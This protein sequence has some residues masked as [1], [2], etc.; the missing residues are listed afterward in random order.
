M[1]EALQHVCNYC[2]TIGRVLGQRRTREDYQKLAT[3]H[4]ALFP[5]TDAM[6]FRPN[7]AAVSEEE[8]PVTS[9]NLGMYETVLNYPKPPQQPANGKAPI[10][11]ALDFLADKQP[12]ITPEWSA[13]KAVERTPKL[14]GTW[15]ISGYQKGR[16]KVYGQMVIEAGS[17]ADD[18][19]T[20]LTL[21]YAA[22]RLEF[23]RTGKGIVY[24]GYSWRGRTKSDSGASTDPSVSPAEM[25]EALFIARDGSSIDGRLYW[26]GY[27]EFGIDVHIT[28]PSSGIVLYGTDK[29]SLKSP[30]TAQLRV[31][32][33]NIPPGLKPGDFD[34]G[35]GVKVV[36]ISENNPA[37]TLLNVEVGSGLAPGMRD[38]TLRGATAVNAFAVYGSSQL[39]QG[40]ARRVVRT[41]RRDDRC[42]TVCPV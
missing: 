8:I 35:P 9:S 21:H 40:H 3:M 31:F 32:G 15:Q 11:N 22:S 5:Y 14:A 30:S 16:G 18:F 41:F 4:V 27:D 6:V 17:T 23:V 39:H 34:L 37:G 7:P 38:V 33:V 28:R 25:K 24:T 19:T 42:E 12:L 1:P 10:D 13:W 36:S 2:H 29:Y 26:G 20:K